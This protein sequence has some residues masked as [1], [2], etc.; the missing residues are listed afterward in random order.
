MR[1]KFFA[2]YDTIQ[3]ARPGTLAKVDGHAEEKQ[4][5]KQEIPSHLS[6]SQFF[7]G[8]RAR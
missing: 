6:C 2:N 8:V 4:V 3:T 7:Q 1:K 5:Y